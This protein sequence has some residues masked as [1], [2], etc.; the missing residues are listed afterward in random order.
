MGTIE[1]A[2]FGTKIIIDNVRVNNNQLSNNQF[3]NSLFSIFPTVTTQTHNIVKG[4]SANDGNYNFKIYS[5]D[6]KLVSEQLANFYGN[7]TTT[8]DVSQ[9]TSGLYFIQCEGFTEKFM[10]N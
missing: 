2:T 10:K 7:N 9:L 3:S 6:G 4:K 1:N 5:I 8:I